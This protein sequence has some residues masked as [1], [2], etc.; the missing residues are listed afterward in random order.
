MRFGGG[1]I[2]QANQNKCF[3]GEIGVG[4]TGYIAMPTHPQYGQ[5]VRVIRQFQA[6]HRIWYQ[7]EDVAHPGFSVQ[8]LASW[9]SASPVSAPVTE[10]NQAFIVLPVSALDKLVQMILSQN[11]LWRVDHHDASDERAGPAAVDADPPGEPPSPEPPSVL[12]GPQP[13]RRPMP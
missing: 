5:A 3:I 1:W 9:L 2:D 8:I 12:H 11:Q 13:D 7:I 4:E 10:P 6:D